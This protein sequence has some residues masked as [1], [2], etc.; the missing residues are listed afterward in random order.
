[1]TALERKNMRETPGVRF[2]EYLLLVFFFVKWEGSG[3]KVFY[4]WCMLLYICLCYL[5]MVEKVFTEKQCSFGQVLPY[6]E[7]RSFNSN[8]TFFG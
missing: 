5:L 7:K 4:S 3:K 2:D 8:F 1:M 6:C